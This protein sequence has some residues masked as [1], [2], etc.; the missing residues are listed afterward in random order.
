MRLFN[1]E[2]EIIKEKRWSRIYR[3]GQYYPVSASKFV[4]DELTVTLEEI[5]AEWDAWTEDERLDFVKAY[6]DKPEMSP[7]DEKIVSF[8]LA[9]GEERTWVLI[10]RLLGLHSDREGMTK[11]LRERLTA[12]S[13]EPKA[14]FIRALRMIGG[15]D[16]LSALKDFHKR[17]LRLT[18]EHIQADPIAIVD[19]VHCCACLAELEGLDKYVADIRR[20]ENDDREFVRLPTLTVLQELSA[21]TS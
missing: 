2:A 1:Q 11:F 12:A 8:L 9:R 6:K 19:F 3:V 13:A 4:T 5:K 10:G 7:G 15:Q 16:A 14:S 21:G 18:T 20:F 17:H